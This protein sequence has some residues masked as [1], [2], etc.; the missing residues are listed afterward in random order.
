MMKSQHP[1]AKTMPKDLETAAPYHGPGKR[2]EVHIP[3]T[4]IQE[5][6][7]S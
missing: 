5:C 3:A 1:I 7:R 2:D 6:S 4:Q